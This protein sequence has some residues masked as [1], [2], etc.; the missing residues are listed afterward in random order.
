MREHIPAKL[1]RRVLQRAGN[2]CE[3]CRARAD[4]SSD[5][6]TV[7]HIVA[8]SQSGLTTEDNLACACFGCNQ[9]KSAAQ[10]ALDPLTQLSVPL[11]HPRQQVWDEHFYWSGDLTQVLALTPTGRATI[12]ALHLNR[13]GLINLRRALRAIGEHP[14]A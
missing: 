1:R 9:H 2:T 4:F 8:L 7:D 10:T 5:P 6:I 3:Y 12:E 13:L 11:F 14:P